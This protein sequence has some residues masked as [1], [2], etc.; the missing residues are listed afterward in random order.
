PPISSRPRPGSG[1]R[2]TPTPTASSASS[3]RRSDPIRRP[4]PSHPLRNTP[5]TKH[6]LCLSVLALTAAPALRGDE[7]ARSVARVAM[8][9]PQ[10][11]ALRV[12]A[13]DVAVVGKVIAVEEKPAMAAQFP[14]QPKVEYRVVVVQIADGLAGT[15]GMTHVRVGF[16]P[17]PMVKPGDQP[18]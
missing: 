16:V 4:G 9:A 17:A 7:D 10:P 2:S 12:A 13:A 6:L 11:A 15:Q 5:V 3:P 8:P 14:G 18:G 1:S